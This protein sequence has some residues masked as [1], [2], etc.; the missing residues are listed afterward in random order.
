MNELPSGAVILAALIS[1]IILGLNISTD[2]ERR[3]RGSKKCLFAIFRDGSVSG[4]IFNRIFFLLVVSVAMMVVAVFI[5]RAGNVYPLS[6]ID[7][8][9]FVF[10][11]FASTAF[12]KY[13]RF[14]YWKRKFENQ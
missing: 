2:Y 9:A 4:V 1:G 10:F 12:A 7:R 13:L 11:W 5:M 14:L 8:Y 3:V 6:K